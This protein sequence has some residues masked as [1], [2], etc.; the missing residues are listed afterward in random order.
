[1]GLAVAPILM[2]ATVAT[3]ALSAIGSIMQGT[4]AAAW[5]WRSHPTLR[6]QDHCPAYPCPEN[7]SRTRSAKRSWVTSANRRQSRPRARANQAKIA[8]TQKQRGLLA[9]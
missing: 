5:G 9:G 1:M 4:Q 7:S 6:W 3:G 2:A 8:A